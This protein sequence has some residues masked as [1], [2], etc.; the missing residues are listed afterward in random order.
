L[1]AEAK[2]NTGLANALTERLGAPRRESGRVLIDAAI[3]RGEV[4][5]DV[6]VE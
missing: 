3:R 2:R 4:R 1:L 6:D 5:P